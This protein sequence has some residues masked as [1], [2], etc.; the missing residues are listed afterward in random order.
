MARFALVVVL[1]FFSLRASALYEVGD[2]PAGKCWNDLQGSSICLND[3]SIEFQVRVLLFNAGWCGPCNSEFQSI[4][5]DTDEFAGRPVTFISLSA[6]G[7]SRSAS[8]D[9]TFLND[10]STTHKLDK[11]TAS[12][13]VAASPRDAGRDYFASPSIPNVVIIDALGK[14][15]YKGINP[16]MHAVAARVRK[17]LPTPVPVPVR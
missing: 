7:W 2:T 1:S 6:A 3:P 12:F 16:G 17:L 4:V 10:W 13:I 9:K 14:V 8:P 5:Q 15:A 11:A